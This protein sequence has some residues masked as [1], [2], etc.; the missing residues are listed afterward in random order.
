[1]RGINYFIRKLGDSV[2]IIGD[3]YIDSNVFD[4]KTYIYGRIE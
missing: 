3:V 4:R 1:M 2:I